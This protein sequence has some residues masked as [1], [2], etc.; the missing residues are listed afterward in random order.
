M[1]KKTRGCRLTTITKFLTRRPR[2]EKL[3]MVTKLAG[4]SSCAVHS[5]DQ[6]YGMRARWS[7]IYSM[8]PVTMKK[9]LASEGH[10]VLGMASVWA[11]A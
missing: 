9:M 1:G 2:I 8:K 3:V 10:G 7:S 5:G 4:L 6:K 11:T